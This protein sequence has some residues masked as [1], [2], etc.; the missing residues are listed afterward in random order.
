M[1]NDR[2]L[3]R[4]AANK[5]HIYNRLKS[6][7]DERG[8]WGRECTRLH[9][10]L[11]WAYKVQNQI[12]E[13]NESAWLQHKYFMDECSRN[14]TAYHAESDRAHYNMTQ[15]FQWS[16]SAWDSGDK[17]GAKSYSDEGK[18][19]QAEMRSAKEQAA[20]WVRQS[21][22]AKYRFNNNS[23][24]HDMEQAKAN[25]KRIKAEFDE[26]NIHLKSVKVEASRLE[27]EFETAKSAFLARMEWLKAENKR[28]QDKWKEVQCESC[29]E[30]FKIHA[31]WSN[32][33]R[34]C[35][36]C[37]ERPEY[38]YKV[39]FNPETGKNDIF[40]G[41]K[42]KADG[43]GHGHAVVDGGSGDLHYLRDTSNPVSPF[44]RGESVI[45]DSGKKI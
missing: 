19:Y 30:K 22:D 26:A 44:T 18:M 21:Q 5:D 8:R 42:R 17:S 24:K 40:F 12:Y 13:S 41:G 4:L 15:A 32:P 27:Q 9:D 34:L 36:K 6:A 3:D 25:T 11:D 37:K 29:K 10:E 45:K 38:D 14:I 23:N 39:R 1:F 7:R 28:E 43:Y 33:P 31:D 16:Q 2:E 20:Y 35:K